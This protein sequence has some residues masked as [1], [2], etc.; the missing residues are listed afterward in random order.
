MAINYDR[1]CL[2][3]YNFHACKIISMVLAMHMCRILDHEINVE[4]Q[5][6]ACIVYLELLAQIR[7]LATV[8]RGFFA[9][10][11]FF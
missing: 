9:W 4:R 3:N 1:K 2:I 10:H 6:I 5:L 7:R 8:V 11:K